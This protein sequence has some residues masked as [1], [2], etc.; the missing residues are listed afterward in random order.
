MRRARIWTAAGVG[1]AAVL[2]TGWLVLAQAPSHPG[3][4]KTDALPQNV[5]PTAI[6]TPQAPNWQLSQAQNLQPPPPVTVPSI[7][8]TPPP[9]PAVVP[10]NPVAPAP[11]PSPA[12][13]KVSGD[14]VQ[15]LIQIINETRSIDTFFVTT[16]LLEDMGAKSRPAVPAIIRNAERL[17]LFKDTVLQTEKDGDKQKRV[18]L[19]SMIVDSLG[20]IMGASSGGATPRQ[21]VSVTPAP[22]VPSTNLRPADPSLLPTSGGTNGPPKVYGSTFR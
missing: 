19:T 22:M 5:F 6:P 7:S 14:L 9:P 11:V 12:P 2:A 16:K 10:V 17:E 4:S 3:P 8:G 20:K 13:V 21:P 1:L 15:E 18:E